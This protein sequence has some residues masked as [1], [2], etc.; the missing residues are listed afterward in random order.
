MESLGH[1]EFEI[2][3]TDREPQEVIEMLLDVCLYVLRAGPVLEH[4]QTF[5]RTEDERLTVTHG[6]SMHEDRGEAIILGM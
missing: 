1:K 6:P 2:H 4:G 5:G 3:Q